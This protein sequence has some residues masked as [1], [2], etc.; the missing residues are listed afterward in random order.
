MLWAAFA[1]IFLI[2]LLAVLWPLRLRQPAPLA[3]RD[4][5]MAVY[6]DQLREVE[7]DLENGVIGKEEAEAARLEVSRKILRL[8]E[9]AG[10]DAAP[11]SA[12]GNAMTALLIAAFM[13]VTGFGVYALKGSPGLPGQPYAERIS[14]SNKSASLDVLVARVED[15][16]RKNPDDA[17]G[18][19]II[20]PSYMKLGRYR[21]AAR[22]LERVMKLNGP[23]A[24]LL[25]GYGE[26]LVMANDG[27]VDD[28]AKKVFRESMRLDA[29]KPTAQYYLGLAEIQSGNKEGAIKRWQDMLA[30]APADAGWRPQI[31]AQIRKAGGKVAKSAAPAPGAGSGAPDIAAM[32]SGLAAKLE[33]NGNNLNGWLMLAR[34]YSVLNRPA[35][36]AKAL[37]S[38]EK[39]FKSDAEAMRKIAAARRSYSAGGA[40]GAA[41]AA[42]SADSGA[43][44][45]G[46]MVAG[47]AERLKEDGNDLKG[48]IMLAQSYMVLKRKDDAVKALQSAESHF[49]DKPEAMARIKEARQRFGL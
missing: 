48:W 44:D 6:K 38:A 10:E 29:T 14:A 23:N 13:A 8:S 17:R 28:Q 18:W 16:L 30:S 43:P 42:P 46:A 39:F 45:I 27:I 19:T 33:K 1:G 41:P 4:F 12:G 11:A 32:V 36:T 15:H 21:D 20:A 40:G 37:D 5:D 25:S 34:A 22:A 47:L 3:R 9:A 2:V 24:V 31:E 49:K 26:A 35:D 7:R